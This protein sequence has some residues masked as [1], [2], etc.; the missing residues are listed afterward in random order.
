M[1]TANRARELLALDPGTGV[2]TWRIKPNRRIRIGSV[3]GSLRPDGYLCIRVEGNIYQC[4]RINWL[5]IHGSWPNGEIDH[6]NGITTDN[7]ITNLRDVTRAENSQNQRRGMSNNKLGVLGVRR[8]RGR[9]T[10][11]IGIDHRVIYLGTFI[12]QEAAQTAY[13]L[14]KQK[15]HP[16]STT[17][18][19]Q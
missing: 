6:I 19:E 18:I 4:H 15:L 8:L 3:A 13:L 2:L 10:A 12:T 1:L 11:Q 16:F 9:F 7:R 5:I 17:R 14:A